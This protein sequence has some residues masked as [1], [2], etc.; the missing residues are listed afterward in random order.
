MWKHTF[1]IIIIDVRNYMLTFLKA[2]FACKAKRANWSLLIQTS[3]VYTSDKSAAAARLSRISFSISSDDSALTLAT[4]L[5][6]S[7]GE[8]CL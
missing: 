5:S 3:V 8:E 2:S 4:S 7:L 6:S 1:F